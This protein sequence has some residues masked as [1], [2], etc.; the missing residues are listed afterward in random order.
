MTPFLLP[1]PIPPELCEGFPEGHYF[2]GA[3]KDYPNPERTL[4]DIYITANKDS[5]PGE[6][7]AW[8][9]AKTMHP[10]YWALYRAAVPADHPWLVK[11]QIVPPDWCKAFPPVPPG[12]ARW[13]P[14]GFGCAWPAGYVD[15]DALWACTS[16]Y[17]VRSSE[18]ADW[19]HILGPS[20]HQNNFYIEAVKDL[21]APPPP[22]S[23]TRFN[24]CAFDC[25]P[26]DG[27]RW[28]GRGFGYRSAGGGPFLAS[29]AMGAWIYWNYTAEGNPSVY[30]YEAVPIASPPSPP[31]GFS[32]WAP[33][34]RRIILPQ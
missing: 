10:D 6:C 30:Y 12:Y 3:L 1:K 31:A 7:D 13:E 28:E 26:P 19:M 16:E 24:Q 25:P 23:P 2:V 33:R 15:E 9:K 29:T 4:K 8:S 27:M 5:M 18:Y 20:G 11:P 17:V 21:A 14:R 32:P 34:K 22:Y